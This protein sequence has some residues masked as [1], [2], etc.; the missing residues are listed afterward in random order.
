MK[1]RNRAAQ[2]FSPGYICRNIRP[3][4]AAEMRDFGPTSVAIHA[5]PILRYVQGIRWPFQGQFYGTL[6]QA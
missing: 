4:R 5:R 2:G 1:W 6:S 3:E